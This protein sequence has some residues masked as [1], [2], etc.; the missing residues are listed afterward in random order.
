[1]T[2]TALELI[3]K[4]VDWW[5]M[6]D[7]KEDYY[8]TVLAPAIVR[9]DD[10]GELMP[11]EKE[12]VPRLRELL[13]PE[14][15]AKLPELVAQE[16]VRRKEGRRVV[17]PYKA[18]SVKAR[19]AGQAVLAKEREK[20][21]REQEAAEERCRK[22]QEDAERE[23]RKQFLCE[24]MRK[25]F[26][27]DFLAADEALAADP[28]CDLLSAD[29]Y[30]Y[31][32]ADFA[33]ARIRQEAGLVLDRNQAAAVAAVRG[34]VQVVARAGS[35]KTRT[36][37]AR[38]VFLQKHCKVRPNEIML[39]AF[40]KSAAENMKAQL[41]PK[42]GTDLP[43]VMTFHALAY[44]LVQ[45]EQDLVFDDP[46]AD[47]FGLSLEVQEVIDEHIRIGD[48][49]ARIRDLMLAHFKDDWERIVKG[50]F[51]LNREEFLN[52]RR[53]LPR[54]SLKGDFVKSFG[55][56]VIA[57]A[58]FEH[59]IDY[60]YER[61]F[62]WNGVV[63]RPDFTIPNG[64]GGGVVIEYFGLQG[65]PD[66]DGMSQQKR[67]FWATQFP[68]WTLLEFS[69]KDIA[70]NGEEKFVEILMKGLSDVGVEGERLPDDV[71]W[72][73]VR[74]RDPDRF[75]SAMK[76]FVGRCRKLNLSPDDLEA[77]VEA[78]TPWSTAEREFISIGAAIY[79]VYLKRIHE[80]NKEDFD[81]M[82]WRSVA[83]IRSG[84][85][86]FIR[87][88]G[89]ETGDLAGL[90]FVMI[91]EFQDF[92]PAFFELVRAIRYVNP[93]VRFFCVGDDWQAINGFAGSD[94][95]Y[96]EHFDKY[97]EDSSRLHM[98]TNYRSARRIVRAGNILMRG[99]GAE[100]NAASTAQGEVRLYNLDDMNLQPQ[101]LTVH[102]G[103]EIT[104]AVLRLVRSFLDH[105]KD[106]VMLS[107]R[108]TVPC[109]VDKKADASFLTHVRSYLPGEDR[110][111][112]TAST[113]HK[114][115]GRES[116]AV[117]VLDALQRSYPLIHPDWVFYRVFGDTIGSIEAEERRLFY[118]ALTRAKDTL[119]LITESGLESPYLDDL[120]TS[121]RIPAHEWS[122][123][124]P[125]PAL[126]G[127]LVDIRVWGAYSVKSELKKQG[128]R[129]HPQSG[130]WYKS[131]KRQGFSCSNL[132]AQPWARA[133]GRIEVWSQAGELLHR[134]G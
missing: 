26:Q 37:A 21:R 118:V 116:A 27:S 121:L 129:W 51:Q 53:L 70:E 131:I 17:D 115:K 43:H 128:Y 3:E 45:P 132:S 40:N 36:L 16:N 117:I 60:K 83:Q 74:R 111:R 107:R 42:L 94:L 59:N 81:G 85:T 130:F 24:R 112:V 110:E 18:R 14:E 125:A 32:K 50:G 102:N 15:W 87:D 65:D 80:R 88:R 66:Y 47:Q 19:E 108:N 57:N 96:F 35:G 55:E 105:G 93:G 12:I 73:R 33:R 5:S 38:A 4:L 46:S 8:T 54:E 9:G 10:W 61:N 49:S 127:E 134:I 95:E 133:A 120:V 89:R 90:K 52:C 78:H 7:L 22:Q 68:K 91:D 31:L 97:F 99:L 71:I 1:M 123:L 29:D 84:T 100:A 72:E 2:E 64:T 44:A 126:D 92:A 28:E 56:R 30:N 106:V 20:R 98:P 103:D 86:R 69:P 75:S 124:P 34:D 109:Y 104:P 6:W 25:V 41:V 101:E 58:L 114:Y 122:N 77:R 63:Y 23:K 13:S 76:T 11:N 119:V 39:L 62:R 67:E 48:Y 82:M 113:V 79:R